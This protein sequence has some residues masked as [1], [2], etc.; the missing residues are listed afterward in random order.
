MYWCLFN[1]GVVI[2]GFRNGKQVKI[3]LDVIIIDAKQG[4]YRRQKKKVNLEA[5]YIKSAPVELG[6][7]SCVE[8]ILCLQ[9]ERSNVVHLISGFLIH[10]NNKGFTIAFLNYGSRF[11]QSLKQLLD[12]SQS[13]SPHLQRPAAQPA[14][15]HHRK[16]IFPQLH[17][18]KG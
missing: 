5:V 11:K 4:K 18:V 17:L 13:D 12:S 10:T 1:E 16:E 14:N 8:L 7:H 2:M 15:N 3:E 9:P 6:H